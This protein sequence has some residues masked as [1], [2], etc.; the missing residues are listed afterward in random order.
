LIEPPRSLAT[1][2]LVPWRVNGSFRRR[3][4]CELAH[5]RVSSVA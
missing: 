1:A 4:C 2:L 5:S 3:R